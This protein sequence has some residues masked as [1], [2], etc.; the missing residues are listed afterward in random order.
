MWKF[1]YLYIIIR[2]GLK[3]SIYKDTS[4]KLKSDKIKK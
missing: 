2:L 1:R 3:L 4:L